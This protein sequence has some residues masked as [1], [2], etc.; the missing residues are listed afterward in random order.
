MARMKSIPTMWDPSLLEKDNLPAPLDELHLDWVTELDY[1]ANANKCRLEKND[2]G[3]GHFEYEVYSQDGNHLVS[4][5]SSRDLM[6][7]TR[8]KRRRRR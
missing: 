1:Y 2:L 3:D 7:A 5:E 4:I 6:L 8:K